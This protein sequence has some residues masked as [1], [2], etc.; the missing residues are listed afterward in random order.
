MD[1]IFK[2]LE[3]QFK[4]VARAK[5]EGRQLSFGDLM[6]AHISEVLNALDVEKGATDGK[7]R[8]ERKRN[9]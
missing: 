2:G 7:K 8:A 1:D 5:R 4:T 9:A 6:G 3:F